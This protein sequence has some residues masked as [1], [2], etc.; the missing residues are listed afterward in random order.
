[1]FYGYVLMIICTGQFSNFFT[2]I[3]KASTDMLFYAIVAFL[4]LAKIL[5]ATHAVDTVVAII[6]SIFYDVPQCQDRFYVNYRE[7][8]SNQT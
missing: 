5:D 2:Y 7:P 1:M 6:C 4:V 8:Q 3:G